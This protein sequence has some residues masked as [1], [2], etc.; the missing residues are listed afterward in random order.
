LDP[1]RF[2][3][4]AVEKF[5]E[6]VDEN[7]FALFNVVAQATRSMVVCKVIFILV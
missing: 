5:E 7:A 6:M 1:L 3:K 2:A 4:A